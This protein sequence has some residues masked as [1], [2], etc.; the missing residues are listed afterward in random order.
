MKKKK[1]K[2]EGVYVDIRPSGSY[3][4]RVIFSYDGEI[5][6]TSTT[7]YPEECFS[8][9]ENREAAKE[10]GVRFIELVKKELDE[11]KE[12]KNPTFRQFFE[13]VYLLKA[14]GNIADTT[15]EFNINT[16]EKFFMPTFGDV[17]LK[18]IS[19]RMLQDKIQ[20]LVNKQNEN[21]EDP[22]CILSQTVERYVSPFR[23]VISMAVREELLPS[24]PFAGG[25]Q[26]PK[27]YMPIIKCMSKDDYASLL[28]SLNDA[29]M[30]DSISASK[31]I[32]ALALLAGLRRGE[33]VALKW[34]DLEHL[35]EDRSECSRICVNAAAYQLKGQKQRRGEPKSVSSKRAFI[36]PKLLSQLLLK[37]KNE[38]RRK[39]IGVTDNDYVIQN[40]AGYMISL[41]TAGRWSVK[42]LKSHGID[43]VKLHSLRHT[44]AAVL[45]RSKMDI[46]TLREI[47]GHDDVRTTQIY[48]YSFKLQEDDLMKDVNAYNDSLIARK[49]EK[50]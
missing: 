35:T 46:E 45:V 7:Y 50:R 10:M 13:E 30:D 44:F 49:E 16:V 19:R 1:E 24:D 47:M 28:E 31:I 17:K 37:W 48:M 8:S 15:Y 4:V 18:S 2:K 25:M 43:N 42:L 23:A 33:I 12:K 38:N 22:V 29:I 26:Y 34:G 21:L 41:G 39:G 40:R 5:I 20:E 11:E 32:V 36:M 6:H 27:M 3:R 9:R 14:R